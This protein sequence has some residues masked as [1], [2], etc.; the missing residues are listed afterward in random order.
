MGFDQAEIEDAFTRFRAA[1]DHGGATGDWT[2][3][4]YAGEGLFAREADV[5]N[6]SDFV[7]AVQGFLAAWSANHPDDPTGEAT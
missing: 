3:L 7:P 6:P 4:L 1:A 5:Y 2:H